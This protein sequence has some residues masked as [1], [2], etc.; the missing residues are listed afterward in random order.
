MSLK[1]VPFIQSPFKTK[2]EWQEY[3]DLPLEARLTHVAILSGTLGMDVVRASMRDQ[4]K[5]GGMSA[6]IKFLDIELASGEMIALV[7]KTAGA[8]PLRAAVGN[9]REALFYSELASELR[10]SGVSVPRCYYSHGDLASGETEMLMEEMV[11]AVPS[12]TFFGGAQP[13]N[14]GVRD[15]LPQLCAGNPGPEEIT[16]DAFKLYA[17]L[18]AAHWRDASL[19]CKSSWLRGAAWHAGTGEASWRAAQGQAASAWAAI[20]PTIESGESPIKWDEHLVACL[21]ASLSKASDWTAYQAELQT[22]PFALVHGDAHAH[23]F[24]WVKQR[25]PEA[26]QRLIDFEM[27]GVGSN[28]QELGQYIISHMPAEMRRA[29]AERLVGVYHAALTAELRS[30]GRDEEASAYSFEACFAEYIAGGAGRWAWFV[31]VLIAMGLPAP[32]NQYFHDQ[33][34]SFLR[35]HIQD[36]ADAPMPR[37]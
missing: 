26:R 5:M 35:D 10:A 16:A 28:A 15:R 23:N 32:M 11:D 4:S 27:V 25:T 12:G 21:D 6:D 29:N 37:V 17:A 1:L 7:L 22:R 19:L 2:V 30:R 33:L 9:A 3:A 8:S 36:P 20:R 13:N 14:W 34:A 31:P 18:H 24:L